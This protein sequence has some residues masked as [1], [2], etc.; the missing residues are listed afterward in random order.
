MKEGTILVIDDNLD[1]LNSLKQLLKYDFHSIQTLSN[2][3]LIP[4]TIQKSE[5]DVIL[6]DMNFTAGINSG[7]EGIFWIREILKIDPTAVIILITAYADIDLTVKAIKEGGTDFIVKPWDPKKLI[8]SLKAGVKFKKTNRKLN[9]LTHKQKFLSESINKQ[10]EELIGNSTEF[11]KLLETIDKIAATDANILL[12]GENGTGKELIA[13]EI[14]KKSNRANEVFVSIDMGSISETLFE[15]EL[16]GHTKGSFTDAKDD[17]MGRFEHASGGTLFLD[18]ITNLS[19][20]LQAKLLS[21]IQNRELI[22]IGGSKAIPIDVR[23]ICATN[24]DIDHLV[25]EQLFREDLLYR[26]NTIQL[27]IPALRNRLAD[28]H[29]LT[30]YYIKK[31]EKKYNKGP[32]KIS[33][34]AI[35]AIEDHRWPGNIREL[36]HAIERAIILSDTNILNQEHIFQNPTQFINNENEFQSLSKLEFDALKKALIHSKGN[37]SKAAKLL[38]IS[39][40]TLYSK[41]EK[42]GL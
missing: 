24:M 22:R 28:I 29:L 21:V 17:R 2:P 18:E 6:L 32:Y 36:K 31:F 1:I 4:E 38:D 41:I 25:A 33:S 5:I 26:I 39:R 40:T 3:N 34:A 42:H 7:N 15:S 13:R 30:D 37:L 20:P 23:L 11:I 27:H 19:F 12:L 35:K 8:T 9:S 10:S 14:H 16:F